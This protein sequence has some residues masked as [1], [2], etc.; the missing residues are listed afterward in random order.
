[1]GPFHSDSQRTSA[2]KGGEK[3][4]SDVGLLVM[5]CSIYRM[6]CIF[7]TNYQGQVSYRIMPQA[8]GILEDIPKPDALIALVGNWLTDINYL[9]MIAGIDMFLHRLPRAPF[10]FNKI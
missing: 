3:F 5:F 9:K 10:V 4:D 6:G 8:V 1:M 7:D 2:T